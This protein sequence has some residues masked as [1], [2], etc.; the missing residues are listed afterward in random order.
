M[1][2]TETSA[3]GLKR[4]YKVVISSADIDEKVDARLAELG[5]T[6]RIPGFRPGKVPASVMKQRYGQAV[7]GEVLERSVTES[8]QQ[9]LAERGVQPAMQPKIEITAFDQG[10]DLEYTMELELMPEIEP[11]D[12]SKLSLERI[13]IAVPDS[14]VEEAMQRLGQQQ[15]KTRELEKARKSK[16]GDVL[17]IDFKGT[18]DGEALPGMEG[19]D[20]HLELG[21]NS[22]VAGFEDQLIGVDK[23]AETTV[24]VTFPEEYVNDKLAGREAIFEVKVKDILETVAADLD[25]DFAKAMG[26]ESLKDLRGKVR[27]QLG[28][29]YDQLARARLKRQLLDQLAD[30]HHFEVPAGMSDLE[31]DAIWKQLEKDREEG[32]VDPDDEG[33]DDDT[34]KAEYRKIAERRVRLGLLLSEVGKRN[35]IEVTQEE[36]NRALLAE[37]QRYPGQERQVLQF[38]Q[39]NPDAVGNL[40]APIFEEKVV[41][42]ITDLAQTTERTLTPED[43]R[44]EYEAAEAGAEEAGAEKKKPAAKK[45]AAAKKAPANKPA[46]KKAAEKKPTEKK[47]AAKKT[48]AKAAAKTDDTG[49][50]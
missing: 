22:F 32:R 42:F 7:M 14:D 1:Q 45:K 17:V 18:V 5:K 6:M 21:S 34:L 47:P 16:S 49:E 19:E 13:K 9:A 31:F 50:A 43:L 46:E 28:G 3:E 4:A 8:S 24:K 35:A 41:D 44:A 39:D 40:R 25:D 33:K 15:R 23:G 29:E 26:A 48:A 2:V 12:F 38:F 30:T 10:K 37:A 11:M 20:H 36:L 27:E